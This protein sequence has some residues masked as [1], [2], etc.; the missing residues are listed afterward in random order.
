MTQILS[1]CI[2]GLTGRLPGLTRSAIDQHRVVTP[3]VL[4]QTP[5]PETTSV[6]P[7]ATTSTTPLE[8]CCKS[9]PWSLRCHVVRQAGDPR[10]TR[11]GPVQAADQLVEVLVA[12]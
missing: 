3:Q 10:R 12:G 5:R 4:H 1:G 8:V 11:Q 2:S 7:A 6:R 9:S